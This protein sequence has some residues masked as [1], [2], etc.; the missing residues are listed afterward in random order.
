MEDVELGRPSLAGRP[1]MVKRSLV[2][3]RPELAVP[4]PQQGPKV[5]FRH[6]SADQVALH[7]VASRQPKELGLLFGFDA[8]GADPQTQR[9]RQGIIVDTSVIV[10]GSSPIAIMKDR[11]IFSE[12]TGS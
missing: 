9:V 2:L 5:A 12:W 10:P 4:S 8:F 11:S 1:Y 7:L 6:G 3:T